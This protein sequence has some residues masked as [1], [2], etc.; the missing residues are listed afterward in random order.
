MKSLPINEENAARVI[1]EELRKLREKKGFSQTQLAILALGY[2][3]FEGT[4]GQ[5]KISK[6]ETGKQPPTIFELFFLLKE[7]SVPFQTFIS[8]ILKKI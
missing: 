2:N 3:K 6:I 7:L 8:D 1:G 4:A 5:G